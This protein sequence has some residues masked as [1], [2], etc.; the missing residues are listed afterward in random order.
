MKARH[1]RLVPSAQ[2]SLP[3]VV[4]APVA[5]PAS[6]C[7]A[8]APH[9]RAARKILGDFDPR[10]AVHDAEIITDT[11]WILGGRDRSGAHAGDYHGNFVPQIPQQLLR[12]FTKPGDVVLDTFCGSGTT[13]IE[14]RRLGRH[15]LAIELLPDIARFAAG[16][17]EE[18]PSPHG[19]R[20][21][22][23][24]GDS[25]EAEPFV[26]VRQRLESLGKPAVAL[27]I[28][29]PPYHDIIKFSENP[30]DLCNCSSVGEFLEKYSAVVRRVKEVLAPKG[31]LGLVIGDMY[32]S[33]EV[34]P[35][36]F[37]CM[38]T[39]LEAGFQ[40]K[41]INVKDIV[42]NRAKRN[43]QNLWRYRAL[44]GGFYIFKHEYIFVFRNR[45]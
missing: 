22:V 10:E 37:L 2:P 1:G 45:S 11:L 26:A 44:V 33:S 6:A 38:Q 28:L 32:Q 31:H 13:M 3:V 40:L 14:C 27:A 23:L 24:V 25:T 15:G 19:A 18:E 20:T 43:Q 12:R 41:A 30:R 5:Q 7:I 9:R 16:R 34:I 21:E 8:E 42:N 39:T 36:G 17:I 4:S 35:L 29:H